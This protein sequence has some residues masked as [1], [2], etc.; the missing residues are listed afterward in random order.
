M[1][2][3]EIGWVIIGLAAILLTAFSFIFRGRRGYITRTSPAV[4]AFLDQRVTAI[5]R[6]ET[7]Q[8]VLGDRFWSRAYPGLELH[9]L[10]VLPGLAG[11][12]AIA[13]GGQTVAAG[14]GELVLFAR[15]ILTGGY[16]DGFSTGL[17][18]LIMPVTLP[19][20]TPLSF[21]AGFLP[22]IGLQAPGSVGLF[23][24]YGITAP[25]LAEGAIRRGGHAFTAA[26]SVTAQAALFLSVSDL[27]IGEEV[28]LMP[29]L[30]NPTPY[31]Q[32]GWMTE[33]ILRA[34]LIA[35]MAIAAIL[36]MVGLL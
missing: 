23:G 34:L 24:N 10:A 21:L 15:Q 29:G 36:K 19:G 28:F 1:T 20:P 27:L 25:M 8:V 9:A 12:E 26:G 22:E 6:G 3:S 18:S 14:S 30:I 4:K 17:H 13:D 5:E 32:A 35:L 2:W 7:R 33:D 16:Q 31:N 11:P